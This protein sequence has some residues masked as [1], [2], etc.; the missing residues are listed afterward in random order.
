MPPC[1][2][3][4]LEPASLPRYRHDQLKGTE[5]PALQSRLGRLRQELQAAQEAAGE[6]A[7]GVATVEAEVQVGLKEPEASSSSGVKSLWPFGL[8]SLLLAVW[9]VA[10]VE[11]EVQVGLKSLRLTSS[12]GVSWVLGPLGLFGWRA[13]CSLFGWWA[14]RRL[15]CRWGGPGA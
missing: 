4:G 13:Y 7:A 11:A 2:R 6:A 15:R 1:P 8:A 14:W 9:V 12:S 5:V 3:F 10:T